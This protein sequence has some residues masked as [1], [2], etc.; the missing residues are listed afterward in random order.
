M[1]EL[2]GRLLTLAAVIAVLAGLLVFS[3][4]SPTS[5]LGQETDASVGAGA[6]P[7]ASL[8]SAGTG[9]DSDSMALL[10]GT[11]AGAGI[12]LLG[13]GYVAQRV[14]RRSSRNG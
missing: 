14:V 3:F 6:N 2:K 9:Y 5:S 1:M 8:P 12:V 7:P 11:M 10:L 4:A 13:G